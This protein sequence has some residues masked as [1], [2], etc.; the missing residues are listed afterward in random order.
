MDVSE[1]LNIEDFLGN[2]IIQ[3]A[4]DS[5]NHSF[6]L[7]VIKVFWFWERFFTLD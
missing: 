5:I 6:L 1:H 4:F 3:K 7:A 2:N